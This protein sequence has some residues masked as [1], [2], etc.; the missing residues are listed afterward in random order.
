MWRD[1]LPVALTALVHVGN[2]H[3]GFVMWAVW[4]NPFL[5]CASFHGVRCLV[6]IGL[7]LYGGDLFI[8]LARP[9]EVLFFFF[10][11]GKEGHALQETAQGHY[12]S[13]AKPR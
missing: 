10:F 8:L 4:A 5:C 12:A 7:P 9:S 3:T 2:G 1:H 6:A 13:H 11:F